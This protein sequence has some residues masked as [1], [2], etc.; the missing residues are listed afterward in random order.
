MG[1]STEKEKYAFGVFHSP[2]ISLLLLQVP[3]ILHPSI[4]NS[5][6][7]LVAYSASGH[8]ASECV[9]II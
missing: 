8:C 2:R 4:V 9:Y 7:V 3:L 6:H 5:Y 1:K